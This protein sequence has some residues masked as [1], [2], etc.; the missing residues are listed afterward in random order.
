ME[1]CTGCIKTRFVKPQE[2]GRSFCLSSENA[3]VVQGA[4]ATAERVGVQPP[5]IEQS[6]EACDHSSEFQA[7]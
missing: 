3:K 7:K 2:G 4:I 5:S 1:R 6:V